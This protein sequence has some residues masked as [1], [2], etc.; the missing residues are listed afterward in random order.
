MKLLGGFTLAVEVVAVHLGERAGRVTCAAFLERMTKEGVGKFDAIVRSTKGGVRHGEKLIGPTLKPTLDLLSEPE[1]LVLSYAALLPPDT[2]PVPWLRVLASRDFPDL[3]LDAQPGYDDPWLSLINHLLGLRLLQTIDLAEDDRSPRLLRMHRLV[4]ELV[5]STAPNPDTLSDRLASYLETRSNELEDKWHLRQWEIPPLIAFARSLLAQRAAIVPT[6]MRSL[7]Q[8][9][10]RFD[11]G[12]H[13]EPMLRAT[14]AQ[15]EEQPTN[16]QS[17]LSTTLS[18]LGWALQELGRH[19]E[20]EK[21]LR[22]ALEIDER[23]PMLNE[24]LLTVRCNQLAGC[25]TALGRSTE[26]GQYA[27]RSLELSERAFGPEHPRTLACLGWVA[28][29]MYNRGDQSAAELLFHRQFK[30]LEKQLG[31]DHPNTLR[32]AMVLSKILAAKGDSAAAEPLCRRAVES[33]KRVFGVDHPETLSGIRELA[34]LLSEKGDYAGAEPLLRRAVEGM[35]GLLGPEHPDTL[36]SVNELARLLSEKGDY[37]GAEPLY[38]RSL[39]ARERV[40]GGTIPTRWR[41]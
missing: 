32:S 10:P 3:G 12:R 19:A 8:W 28:A 40:L 38:R 21:Y 31:F 1:R 7:C 24:G 20:A 5:R 13:S 6:F 41:A 25:L 34:K 2:I 35:E 15:I 9:L 14:L 4:G 33:R 16:D 11:Y 17:D 26:A 39:E 29:L 36:T 37:A 18:N 22:R 30:G 23:S 27:K